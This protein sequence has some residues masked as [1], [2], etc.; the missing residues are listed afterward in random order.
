MYDILLK[1]STKVNHHNREQRKEL[2]VSL[3]MGSTEV[4]LGMGNHMEDGREQK[5]GREISMFQ[6]M[7]CKKMLYVHL[8][9]MFL[10]GK[11]CLAP[12]CQLE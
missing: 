2:V 11:M 5:Y 10:K 4:S 1:K 8:G 7:E 12:F 6:T 9:Y 3:G